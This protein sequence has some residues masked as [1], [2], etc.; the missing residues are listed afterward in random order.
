MVPTP[1]R[2]FKYLYTQLHVLVD[3]VST[4]ESYSMLSL[5]SRNILKPSRYQTGKAGYNRNQ[6]FPGFTL[7]VDGSGDTR[8]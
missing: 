5:F 1:R 4:K 7:D 2:I 8:N 6:N 3:N